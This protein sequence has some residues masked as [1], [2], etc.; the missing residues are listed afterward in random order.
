VVEEELLTEK[1]MDW[2]EEHSTIE[3]VPEGSLKASEEDKQEEI[4]NSGEEDA[5]A[6][7]QVANPSSQTDTELSQAE[8]E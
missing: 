2:L 6:A 8:T 1:I 3:L 7:D 4:L 5:A